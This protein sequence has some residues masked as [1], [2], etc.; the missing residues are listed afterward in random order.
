[1][2]SG[3]DI[4]LEPDCFTFNLTNHDDFELVEQIKENGLQVDASEVI[5]HHHAY[6]IWFD[7]ADPKASVQKNNRSLEF[8]NYFIGQSKYWASDVHAFGE[9]IYDN[10]Y[11][12]ID[13]KVYSAVANMK[14]DFIVAPGKNV[15]QI[16]LRYDGVDN[17]QILNGDLITTTSITEITELKP[18]AYQK[19]KGKFVAVPCAFQLTGNIVSFIFPEG[20]NKNLELIID[21][22]MV[23]CSYTGSTQDNWGYTATY[24]ADGDLYGGGIVFGTGYP[25][26][27][28][29]YQTTFGGGD[30]GLPPYDS[31]PP[32]SNGCDIAISKFNPDGT[33]LLY[34]TY[35]GGGGNELPHSLV[36]DNAGNLIV[37]GTSGSDDYPVTAGAY[38]E[39]YND[40]TSVPVDGGAINFPNGVDIIISKLSVDGSSLL[41][42]TYIGGS[43]N[44]GFNT[45]TATQYNYGDHA[46]G[47]VYCDAANNIYVASSTFSSDFP[48]TA[49]C[50]Q[51]TIGGGQDGC[52]FKF[53][54]SLTSLTWSTF[55]GGASA[56]GAYS[57][58]LNYDG[59]VLAAGGTASSAFPTTAG[60]W[61]TT[62][63]GGTADGWVARFSS[64][65]TS[66][67][68]STF[69]GTTNYDQA[70]FVE[71]DGDNNIYI[72]G[73]TKGAFTVSPGVYSNANGKQFIA[74]LDP[75]LTGPIYSTVFGSGASAINLSPSAFLV[76]DCENV[77]VSGWGGT[78][79]T[80]FNPA[81]GYT[82]GMVVSPDAL[83]ATTDGDDFYFFVLAKNAVSLLYASFFGG[84]FNF[85]EH[86]D[87]GTSRF[88][89]NGTIYQ[90]CCASCG[91]WDDMPVTPGA[92]STTNGSTN[93]NLGVVKIDFNLAGVNASADGEPDL[94]GCAPF[95]VDF[96]NLS[97]GVD[98]IWDFD[99]GSPISNLF[100]PSHTFDSAGI[101]NVMLIA[102]DSNSCNISDTLF[103]TITVL[104]D[105]ISADFDYSGNEDCDSLLATFTSTGT[106]FP[107]TTY[108]WDFGDGTSSAL[109]NPIHVYYDPGEYI[110]TLIVT[111]PNS[112]NG[113][114]TFTYTI[115]YLYEF[116]T[117]FAV[118][119]LGCLPVTATFASNFT[120][121]D[122]YTWIFGDSTTGSGETTTHIYTE[123]G[124]YIVMLIT[125]NCGIPD[126]SAQVVIIDGWPVAYFSDDPTQVIVNTVVTFTNLSTNAVAYSWT[127][128]DGG[129]SIVK[130][131]THI[132]SALGTYNVCLTA[133]NTNG[134]SDTYCRDVIVEG[135]GIVD[136]PTGF[137]PDNDGVNDLISVK[138]FGIR[139][140]NFMIFNRWGEMVFQTNDYNVGWDGTYRNVLQEMEVYAY[141][142]K[143]T[144]MDGNEFEQK[145]NITLL[146]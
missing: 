56:D 41:A 126:T 53:N 124:T 66:L 88:D 31:F 108:D 54:S 141:Y 131:A 33:A 144:F 57:L 10:L 9:V 4:F 78:V 121:G 90:A 127:F 45:S 113:V 137:T 29:A 116:N 62:Y 14:Y 52:V 99:D 98:F 43:G 95:A 2:T 85:G 23:F 134:C 49:G 101:Y 68:A 27:V 32:Y 80:S 47:E 81:A 13:L 100:E 139:E 16:Q 142:L 17:L 91:G 140:M 103:L 3:A 30:P 89:K 59:D 105:S 128:S 44:D 51:S 83:D 58:K 109:Q 75:D 60:A 35:L 19:I 25:T 50:F 69:V 37:Y 115:N 67:L 92:Y 133:T 39:T 130:N 42:S 146:R 143:G 87:G 12:G 55:I 106:T 117:G 135:A 63:I 5:M 111:D 120:D 28:G 122:T 22:T 145:G 125:Y 11:P 34:S 73:Q 110:V 107:T 119:A 84:D 61:H 97:L 46:R 70:Y 74:K 102:I 82:T 76:D 38:D 93:C 79:N 72:T 15:N 94:T 123:P 26:T 136:V 36:V 64:D 129:S 104:N 6:K 138:G 20:Y 71:K 48:T 21:P 114:D 24:D 65:G 118:E 77:Y 8:Y 112:C 7:G 132:F 40:G 86:V 18:Y 96:V 1:M